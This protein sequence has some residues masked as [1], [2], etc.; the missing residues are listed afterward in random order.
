MDMLRPS[1]RNTAS[2]LSLCLAFAL[3]VFT[4]PALGQSDLS[5]EIV[6]AWRPNLLEPGIERLASQGYTVQAVVLESNEPTVLMVREG[7]RQ[8]P[9]LASYRVLASGQAGEVEKLAGEGWAFHRAGTTFRGEAVVVLSRRV[10]GQASGTAL[11]SLEL[12][13]K[14][15]DVSALE[16]LYAEGFTVV[17]ALGGGKVDWLLFERRAGSADREARLIAAQGTQGM[18]PQLDSLARE[19]LVADAVWSRGAGGFSLTG[20]KEL[21]AVLSRPRLAAGEQGRA[22]WRTP[23]SKSVSSRRSTALW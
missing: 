9:R 14:P 1:F 10:P 5:W 15:T 3:L 13:A 17:A 6:E 12:P 19:G 11:R 21:V 4:A 16:R 20:P 7:F 8:A 23:G 18:T 2:A 22:R